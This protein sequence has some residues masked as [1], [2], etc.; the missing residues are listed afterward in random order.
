MYEITAVIG[1]PGYLPTNLT[2]E[3]VKLKTAKPVIVDL[4]GAEV[5]GASAQKKID[6]LAG[7][8]G[9]VTGAFYGNISTFANAAAKKKLTWIVK[10]AE[11]TVITVKASQEKAGKACKQITL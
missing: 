4:E 10:A 1:N 2:E 9:T 8:S 7:F 5:I 3:A 6:S 11:G